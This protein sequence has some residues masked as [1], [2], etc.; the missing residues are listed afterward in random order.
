MDFTY[1][2]SGGRGPNDP[3]SDLTLT[4]TDVS[5]SARWKEAISCSD[6][7]EVAVSRERLDVNASET[8]RVE[9][10][11]WTLAR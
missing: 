2:S 4:T 5:V 3:F 11:R 1:A 9:V 7:V 10:S 8:V 6:Q